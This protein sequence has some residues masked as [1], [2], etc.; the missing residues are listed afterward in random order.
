M[1]RILLIVC[2]GLLTSIGFAQSDAEAENLVNDVLE[3]VKSYENIVIDFSYILENQSENIKQE[4]RG[5]V[6]I[7]G[8]KYHLNLMGATRIFDGKKM[9]T[10]V[11]EDEEVTISNYN[12]ED[13]DEITPSKMLTFYEEGYQFEMD[14]TQN[15]KGRKIQFVKLTP[16]D[17]DAEIKEI[18]LG[19][20]QRTKHIH[21][22]IQLQENGT[23]TEIKVKSFKTNQPISKILFDF[24]EEKYSDYY[25]N[26]LD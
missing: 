13:D 24:N 25:I 10:I 21:T 3:K 1:K 9:Y 7:K 16:M 26:R 17:S 20:D 14:I 15:H 2:F 18:Y 22:L 8:D 19:I 23:K 6:T 4:T 11:P 12:P 5:D